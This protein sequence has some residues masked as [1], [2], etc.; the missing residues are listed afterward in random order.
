[1]GV[2]YSS[3]FVVD[4]SGISCLE[5]LRADDNGAWIHGGKPHR[6]YVVDCDDTNTVVDVRSIQDDNCNP[7]NVFTLVWLYRHH[8]HTPEFQ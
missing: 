7:T 3:G 4:L 1:V 5:D 8:K 6:K 2:R